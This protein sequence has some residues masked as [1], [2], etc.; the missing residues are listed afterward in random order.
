MPPTTPDDG[1]RAELGAFLR[2]RR[3]ALG[4][5]EVGLDPSGR[6][7][8]PGLRREEV[9]GLA[10]VSASWYTWLEQGRPINP[11]VDV[12]EAL[13]RV[14]HLDAAAREHLLRLAGHAR[15]DTGTVPPLV[16]DTLWHLLDQLDPAPAY[17]LGPH[18]DYLAWN[19]AHA[20]LFPSL[21]TLP[22]EDR[23]LLWVVFANPDAR[24]LIDGWED[25][26]RRV[27]S[28]FRTDTVARRTDPAMVALVDRLLA[29]SAEFRAWWP[30][31]DV[32]GPDPRVRRFRHPD[33]GPLAFELQQLVPSDAP[34]LRVFVHLPLPGD[35]S[36]ARLSPPDRAGR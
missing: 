3:A 35:D 15:P 32:A 10:G 34:G 28:E 23:N 26:A 18:W 4:P 14:L 21:P 20:R 27:L 5:E 33:A 19:A 29:A 11:S 8:T 1:R 36:L 2:A 30:S 6:R 22:D 9:A 17:V 12:L 7:R 31:Q 13:A 16:P 25:E 24:A